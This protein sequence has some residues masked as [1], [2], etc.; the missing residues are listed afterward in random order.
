MNTVVTIP[1]GAVVGGCPPS[2]ARRVPLLIA[3]SC[4]KRSGG[5]FDVVELI[6]RATSEPMA[7]VNRSSSASS[8][9]AELVSAADGAVAILTGNGESA[10]LQA[11]ADS[12]AALVGA[13]RR[14]GEFS[15]RYVTRY[16]R[17]DPDAAAFVLPEKGDE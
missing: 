10:V 17:F 12:W 11:R 2:R 14:R 6:E 8:S 9:L 5:A 15:R 1:W 13:T 16:A 3:S 4:F 7:M